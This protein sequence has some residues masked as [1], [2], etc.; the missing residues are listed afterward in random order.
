MR[1]LIILF[2]VTGL[3]LV[4]FNIRVTVVVVASKID[5]SLQKFLQILLVWLVPFVGG[6]VTHQVHRGRDWERKQAL[7]GDDGGWGAGGSGFH[8]DN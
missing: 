1:F 7:G 3:L 8:F 5:S 4:I 6:I 2:S